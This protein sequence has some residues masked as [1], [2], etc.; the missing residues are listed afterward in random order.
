VADAGDAQRGALV[1]VGALVDGAV[2]DVV[3]G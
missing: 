1:P 3:M 2:L